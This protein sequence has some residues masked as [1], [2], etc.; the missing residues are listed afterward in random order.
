M[1]R[2]IK[3][4]EP[5]TVKTSEFTAFSIRGGENRIFLLRRHPKHRGGH[6]LNAVKLTGEENVKQKLHC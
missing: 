2:M 6:M 5:G 3:N 1:D 4:K